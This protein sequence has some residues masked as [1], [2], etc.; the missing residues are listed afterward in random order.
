MFVCVCVYKCS[1]NCPLIERSERNISAFLIHA[2]L[3]HGVRVIADSQSC[4]FFSSDAPIRLFPFYAVWR[5]SALV[6]LP[7]WGGFN[8]QIG[9][10]WIN[11]LE[12]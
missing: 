12:L 7:D 1:V 3:A 2:R 5:A 10:Y 11:Q 4:P 8:P 6:L 9:L